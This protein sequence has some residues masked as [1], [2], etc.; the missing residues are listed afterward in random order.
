MIDTIMLDLDGTL[1][2]FSQDAFMSAY[3]PKLKEVFTRLGMDDELCIKAM[4]AGTHAMVRNDG[5]RLNS[6]RFWDTFT[7]HLG[8]EAEKLNEVQAACEQ[9]YSKE[10]D[11]VRTIVDPSDIPKR[12]IPALASKGYS[13]VLATNPLFPAC[14]VE[15]RLGWAGLEMRNFQ[16]TT[17]YENSSYC[18]PNP[19]YFREIFD[20]MNREPSQCFMAG[21]NPVEDMCV[22]ELGSEIFLVTDCLENVDGVDITAFRRGTLS[23]LER[24]L[25]AMPD[26][27]R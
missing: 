2:R 9:F 1:L 26:I 12:L 22:G 18:K 14:A 10:F 24:Y 15:T 4:W 19:G 13:V 21:N 6:Q 8:L 7:E 11:A 25:M 5:E 27:A 23:E 20:K 3:F 16:L 17:H